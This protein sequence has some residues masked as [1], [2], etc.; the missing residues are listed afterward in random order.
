MFTRWKM[1]LT[2]ER[3]KAQM[4]LNK[5]KADVLQ[6]LKNEKTVNG[7]YWSSYVQW[8]NLLYWPLNSVDTIVGKT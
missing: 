3:K 6:L 8:K 5:V 7:K 1:I 2:F 4:I